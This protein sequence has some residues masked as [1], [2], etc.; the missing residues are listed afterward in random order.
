LL[1]TPACKFCHAK[2]FH[3][4]S[5]GFYCADG[6]ISLVSNDVPDELYE[7]FTSNLTKSMEFLKYVCIFNNKFALMSYGVKY[8]KNLCRETKGYIRSEFRVK[9]IIISMII[10][11]KWLSFLFAIVF[12]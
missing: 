5:K 1:P 6:E 8:D 2:R 3:H 9:S 10:A 11:I 12:L 7:M 4:E